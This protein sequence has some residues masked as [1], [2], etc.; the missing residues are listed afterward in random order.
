[1]Q[2]MSLLSYLALFTENQREITPAGQVL[3]AMMFAAIA[4]LLHH[5]PFNTQPKISDWR[6]APF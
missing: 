6:F 2:Q 3:M 4:K 5:V 1:M